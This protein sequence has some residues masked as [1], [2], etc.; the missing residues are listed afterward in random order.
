MI[1][2][3]KGVCSQAIEVEIQDQVI[4]K[5]N[6]IGGCPGNTSGIA[7]L[8]V[9]MSPQEVIDKLEGTTCGHR[10]TSCPDQLSLALKEA[11]KE[12]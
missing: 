5:V 6:F 2:K 4:K 9:G 7:K 11:L 12:Q 1:Y 8:V 3:T 10:K